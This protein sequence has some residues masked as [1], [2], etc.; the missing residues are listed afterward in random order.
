MQHRAGRSEEALRPSG[1]GESCPP[2]STSETR[3]PPVRSERRGHRPQDSRD[4][5]I[6]ERRGATTWRT[7]MRAASI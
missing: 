6:E 7:V 2:A 3:S 4:G 5:S 1:E